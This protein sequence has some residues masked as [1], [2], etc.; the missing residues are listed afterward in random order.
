MS[1]KLEIGIFC[2]GVIETN[3]Y[4]VET[5][6]GCLVI[7]APEGITNYVQ[8]KGMKPVGLVL[9]HGHW[10][11]MWEAAHFAKT[12]SCPVYYHKDDE[13]ICT[14]PEQMRSFGLPVALDPIPKE[15]TRFL[16]E[17]EEFKHGDVTFKV[18]HVP[19]HCPGSICLY[20]AGFLFCGDVI[21]ASGIG[22]WDLPGGSNK[23]LVEGIREK[24]FTLPDE[25]IVYPGH[26]P[27]TTIGEEKES[28]PF[29]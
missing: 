5:D 7:D 16:E 18:F 28:N 21:F 8:E 9:T 1:S 10:D 24:L 19:G 14:Q 25:T 2:G 6:A 22:R 3:A 17:G 20:G 27:P 15:V 4:L 12:F 29:L 11:H 23:V 13:S 26:G